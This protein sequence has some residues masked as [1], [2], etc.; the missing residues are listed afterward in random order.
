M[1]ES[2]IYLFTSDRAEGWGAVLNESMNSACA[3]V[4]SPEP[5]AAPFLIK[6]GYNGLFFKNHDWCDMSRK[7]MWLIDNPVERKRMAREAYI[8]MVGQWSPKVA[9]ANLVSL[10]RSV[11]DGRKP[12][13]SD[14]PCS[15]AGYLPQGWYKCGKNE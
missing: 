10:I 13:I 3:V 14:G 9:A 1:E 6:D 4:S 15:K 12:E 2:D 5:G 8:T 11:R 7:V